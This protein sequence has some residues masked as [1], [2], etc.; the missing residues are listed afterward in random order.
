MNLRKQVE[1]LLSAALQ[2]SSQQRHAQHATSRLAW[3]VTLAQTSLRKPSRAKQEPDD[4][5]VPLGEGQ[6]ED[7]R[8]GNDVDL[9]GALGGDLQ[10]TLDAAGAQ[11]AIDLQ[12]LCQPLERVR[13]QCLAPEIPSNELIRRGG[14]H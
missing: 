6:D 5:T 14:E 2:A 3:V 11:D 10:A 7:A 8:A 13:A 1:P 4:L 9:H 12:G